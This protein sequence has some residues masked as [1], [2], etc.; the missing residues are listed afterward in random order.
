M[1]GLIVSEGVCRFGVHPGHKMIADFNNGGIYKWHFIREK[2]HCE[3]DGGV[4]TVQVLAE[5]DQMV[6]PLV[7]IMQMLLMNLFH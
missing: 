3:L 6:S 2:F 7:Q 4:S 5:Q 1:M